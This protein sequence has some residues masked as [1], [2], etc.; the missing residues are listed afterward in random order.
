M[1]ITLSDQLGP[2]FGVKNAIEAALD[3]GLR[4][5]LTIVG[6][7]IHN[8]QLIER[9]KEAGVRMVHSLDE[10]IRTRHV[11]ITAHGASESVKRRA[12]AM[13]FAVHDATCPLV[14][15]VHR[16]VAD[17]V[18]DGYYPVVIGQADHVEVKGIVG[19]LAGYSIIGDPP[20]EI[21][22]L[23]GKPKIGIVCQ[24]TQ[25]SAYVERVV[26][27]IRATCP[28]ADIKLID[29]ICQVTKDR[30]QALDRLMREVDLMIVVGGRNSSNTKKLTSVCLDSGIEAHQVE[31]AAEL[32]AAWFAGKRHAGIT[33]GTSTPNDVVDAV[34]HAI[35]RLAPQ[36]AG[37]G[38]AGAAGAAGGKKEQ[39]SSGAV[40]RR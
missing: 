10:S 20:T 28:A 26:A 8:P 33:A 35:L 27:L 19:D 23:A 7:L 12:G 21:A 17:L 36:E 6:D 30:Q 38:A 37:A 1:K 9:L 40:D 11:M 18:R 32:E 24:T 16:A 25:R 15:R 3:A 29:T 14:T 22:E 5:D 4:G 2:C 13:G 34:Y 31:R 39:V